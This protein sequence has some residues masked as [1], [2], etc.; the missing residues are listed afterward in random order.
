MSRP[1]ERTGRR[2]TG[3]PGSP[4]APTP[5]AAS[6]ADTVVDTD[7]DTAA[8][9]AVSNDRSS[10]R[11]ESHP[12]RLA[13]LVMAPYLLLALAWVFSNPPGGAPDE[14]DHLVKAL[15]TA[16]LEVGAEGPPAQDGVAPVVERNAS[17][18]RLYTVPS[19]LSPAGFTCF[20]F[21]P[22]VSAA[23]LPDERPADVG[24]VALPTPIGDYPPFLYSPIG[25]AARLGSSPTEAFIL[26]RLATVAMSWPLLVLAAA[27]L[28]RWLGRR[29]V[30]GLVWALTPMAIFSTAIVSTSGIEI[31]A[32]CAVAAVV[33]AGIHRPESVTSGSTFTVLAI[34][35]G[36]LALSRHL[37]V[38]ALALFLAILVVNLG[39]AR[40][41][42]L[43]RRPTP[44]FVMMVVVLVGATAAM[45]WW[46]LAHDTAERLGSVLDPDA[47]G[48]FVKVAYVPIASSVGWFGWFDTPLPNWQQSAWI[49]LVVVAVGVALLTGSRR[50]VAS[51]GAYLAALALLSYLTFAIVFFPVAG[52]FQGRQVL[53]LLTFLP[54]MA[55]AVLTV[56]HADGRLF[57]RL[58]VVTGVLVAVAHALA[59]FWNARRYATGLDAPMWFFGREEWAPRGGWLVWLLLALVGAAL[60]G[61]VVIG[62]LGRA[63][64][65]ADAERADPVPV[66]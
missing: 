57:G 56:P 59:V 21:Q 36:A 7:H 33:V 29:A 43:L 17:T 48:R 31:A 50:Q 37:G 46:E 60:L 41:R 6:A 44:S 4:A 28:L 64:P 55:A 23:C 3:G 27:H 5:R 35:G 12:Y 47:F 26:G 13:L 22:D 45:A 40:L 24:D 53:P 16:Q 54:I 65:V 25:W 34:G 39:W 8:P 2:D 62:I 66:G 51:I 20:A 63:D 61:T 1:L 15:G 49:T 38:V 10:A 18:T 9:T 11:V 14:P 32:A 30:L 58:A 52:I 42:A 19:R